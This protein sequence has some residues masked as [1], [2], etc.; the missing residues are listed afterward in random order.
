MSFLKGYKT[1]I[2]AI[3]LVL[4]AIVNILVGDLSM[5]EFLTDPSL[6]ILLNG[7]GI[8]SLRAALK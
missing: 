1:Y 6:L 2:I 4:V 8:G 7:L 3:L 5:M